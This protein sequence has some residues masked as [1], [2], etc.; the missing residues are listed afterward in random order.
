MRLRQACCDPH[1]LPA[2][3]VAGVESAAKLDRLMEL[4]DALVEEGHRALVFSQWPS[5]LKRVEPRLKARKIEYLYLD[6]ATKERGELQTRWN[7]DDGPPLFLISLPRRRHRHEPGG[8]R[9][10]DPP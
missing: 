4:V 9:P 6:G 3:E 1:L 8:R 10:C 7:A 5:L 2:T